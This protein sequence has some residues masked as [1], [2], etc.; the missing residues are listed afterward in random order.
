MVWDVKP[1]HLVSQATQDCNEQTSPAPKEASPPTLKIRL[2]F[3]YL[4]FDKLNRRTHPKNLPKI[5]L[6]A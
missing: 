6:Y 2:F 5:S 1:G 3:F 4:I